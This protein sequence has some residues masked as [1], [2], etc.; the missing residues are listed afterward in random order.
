MY[1]MSKT[2]PFER[3]G[4]ACDPLVSKPQR[5]QS[6]GLSQTCLGATGFWNLPDPAKENDAFQFQ[7]TEWEYKGQLEI[8]VLSL[9]HSTKALIQ[10]VQG[11]DMLEQHVQSP[12]AVL[13][14]HSRALAEVLAGLLLIQLPADVTEKGAEDSPSTSTPA[15]HMRN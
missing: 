7:R 3:G 11:P 10:L 15:S 12:F 2:T 13:A 6:Q 5:L 4:T 1:V 8:Q 14:Y 9:P